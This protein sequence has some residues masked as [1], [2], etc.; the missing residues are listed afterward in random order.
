MKLSTGINIK[1]NKGFFIYFT[2]IHGF[3][4]HYSTHYLEGRCSSFKIDCKAI[5]IKS[6]RQTQKVLNKNYC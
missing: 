3:K 5:V 6:I 4:M 2:L 1:F